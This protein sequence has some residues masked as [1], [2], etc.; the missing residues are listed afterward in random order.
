MTAHWLRASEPHSSICT[1]RDGEHHEEDHRG[2]ERRGHGVAGRWEPLRGHDI[3]GEHGSAC[4]PQHVEVHEASAERQQGGPLLPGLPPGAGPLPAQVVEAVEEGLHLF[5]DEGL[6]L[7]ALQGRSGAPARGGRAASK[8]RLP[9]RTLTGLGRHARVPGTSGR[10]SRRYSGG[11]TSGWDVPCRIAVVEHGAGCQPVP[12]R[13]ALEQ[14]A[15]NMRP[16]HGDYD[17]ARPAN[18]PGADHERG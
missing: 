3:H 5:L 16:A 13:G 15:G 10:Q 4:S 6:A 9:S 17:F 8:R 12:L 7:S 11:C 1:S 14:H 18:N 2:D